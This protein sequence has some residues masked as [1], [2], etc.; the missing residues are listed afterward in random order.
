MYR[1]EWIH[2]FHFDK[3][4]DER[5]L[6][7]SDI[8]L[9]YYYYLEFFHLDGGMRKGLDQHCPFLPLT[10]ALFKYY[11]VP[12]L[13]YVRPWLTMGIPYDNNRIFL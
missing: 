1:K 13:N 12:V 3:F 6:K 8:D 10:Q 11:K 2:I 7:K 4:W 5:C 9:S